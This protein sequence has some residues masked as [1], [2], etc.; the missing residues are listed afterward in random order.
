MR[1]KQAIFLRL[2]KQFA[3]V[4]VRVERVH[5]YLLQ[6]GVAIILPRH[7]LIDVAEVLDELRDGD[8]AELGLKAHKSWLARHALHAVHLDPVWGLLLKLPVRA[9]EHIYELVG[10]LA[11]LLY[12][13]D[14]FLILLKLLQV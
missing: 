4:Q 10:G 14:G 9:V 3:I 2:A 6:A 13:S 11:S 1:H 8:L 12:I 7:A 5:A